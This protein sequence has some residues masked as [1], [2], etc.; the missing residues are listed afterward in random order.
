ML[1]QPSQSLL[2]EQATVIAL[3][4]QQA[5]VR[6]QQSKQSC[7]TCQQRSGCGSTLLARFF[8]K[9]TD[10]I[11][12]TV[13]NTQHAQV[14]DTVTIAMTRKNLLSL[15]FALYIV[16]LLGLFA[17]ALL[18]QIIGESFGFSISEGWTAVCGLAGL[19]SGWLAVYWILSKQ[20]EQHA[21]APRMIASKSIDGF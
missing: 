19:L 12:F 13:I 1:N 14:G 21:Y 7:G 15:S 5:T 18:Y 3:N 2:T 11:S 17:G 4:E 9:T 8:S 6:V 16:P 20:S 10:P